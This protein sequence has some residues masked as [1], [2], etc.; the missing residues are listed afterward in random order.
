LA[1]RD[2]FRAASLRAFTERASCSYKLLIQ[3]NIT[4]AM[5]MY[6]KHASEQ[7]QKIFETYIAEIGRRKRIKHTGKEHKGK[8]S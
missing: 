1:L 5:Y 8:N 3:F 6:R 4:H 7:T 2:I